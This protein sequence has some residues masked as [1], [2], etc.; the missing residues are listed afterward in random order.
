M[1]IAVTA[2]RI[3]GNMASRQQWDVYYTLPKW[4]RR[5]DSLRPSQNTTARG[6]KKERRSWTPPTWLQDFVNQALQDYP[7]LHIHLY[8]SQPSVKQRSGAS[9]KRSYQWKQQPDALTGPGHDIKHFNTDQGTRLTCCLACGAYH[10]RRNK[11]LRRPCKALTNP[12]DIAKCQLNRV[13][14]GLHPQA[15]Q[16]TLHDFQDLTFASTEAPSVAARPAWSL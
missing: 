9:N 11:L 7:D 12:D 8:P 10:G 4:K 1:K 6:S 5:P 3:S 2:G 13:L 16:G 14:R 15:G